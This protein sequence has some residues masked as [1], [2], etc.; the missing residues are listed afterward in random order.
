MVRR[1]ALVVLASLLFPLGAGA[2][3]LVFEFTGKVVYGGTL[4]PVGA[5]VTGSFS[6]D[7]N[8]RPWY[9]IGSDAMYQIPAP[10]YIEVNVNGHQALANRLAARV[11]NNY[12]GNVEDVV[13][14]SGSPGAMVDGEF[15]PEGGV[16]V[17]FSSGPGSTDVL[18]NRR[19][20][21]GY[22]VQA[23]DAYEG[24][25]GTVQRNGGQDGSLLQ[26]TIESV[27]V[28]RIC[29]ANAADDAGSDCVVR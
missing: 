20:P 8:T 5:P 10:H 6:Y 7:T 29:P 28:H 19:L 3:E 16:G 26:F 13:T 18:R 1:K 2:A 21:M 25:G 4:A 11:S 14:L 27:V 24:N 12:G 15:L 23:F 9:V 22:D 17:Y